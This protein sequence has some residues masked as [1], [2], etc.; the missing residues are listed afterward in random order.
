[1]FVI[2]IWEGSEISYFRVFVFLGGFMSVVFGMLS[3]FIQGLAYVTAYFPPLGMGPPVIGFWDYQFQ[4]HGFTFGMLVSTVGGLL[5]LVSSVKRYNEL[6]SIGFVGSFLGVLGFLFFPSEF[7]ISLMT[8]EYYF[9]V[10]W[11]G[12]CL[13][14]ISVSLMLVGLTSRSKGWHYWTLLGVPLLLIGKLPHPL[15]IL[16]NNLQFLSISNAVSWGPLAGFSIILGFALTLS[17]SAIGAWKF[18][19]GLTQIW[20][21]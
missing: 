5:G 3:A 17:G 10:L 11:V 6:I 20:H 14:L 18:R 9:N 16:S 13:T 1:M 15:S 19:A 4:I 21:I 2:M 12:P 8:G 7:F